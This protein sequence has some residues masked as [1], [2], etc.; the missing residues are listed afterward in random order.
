VAGGG[1]GAGAP[2]R[3]LVLGATIRAIQASRDGTATPGGSVVVVLLFAAVCFGDNWLK[4][5]A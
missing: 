5:S 1:R 4:V 3:P 2:A